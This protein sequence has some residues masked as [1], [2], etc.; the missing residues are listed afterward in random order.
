MALHNLRITVIDGGKGALGAAGGTSEVGEKTPSGRDSKLY[1][2]LNLN[3]EVRK[4]AR[5][6]MSSTQLLAV[7]AGVNLA[8]QTGRQ[9]INYYVSDIGRKHGDTNYQ[10]I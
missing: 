6:S 10:A 4:K 9:F 5:S 3:Q 1:K 2:M 7:Q 8:M